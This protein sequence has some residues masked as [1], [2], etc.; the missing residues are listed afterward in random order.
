MPSVVVSPERERDAEK[1]ASKDL[2]NLSLSLSSAPSSSPFPSPSSSFIPPPMPGA[3]EFA[4]R[5]SIPSSKKKQRSDDAA[6]SPASVAAVAAVVASANGGGGGAAAAPPQLHSS[7]TP[8]AQSPPNTPTAKRTSLVVC[9]LDNGVEP[10]TP[11]QQQHANHTS[12]SSTR[13]APPSPS[14]SRR[15]SGAQTGAASRPVSRALSTATRRSSMAASAAAQRRRSRAVKIRDFAFPAGDPRHTGQGPDAPRASAEY[16][17]PGGA[18][19]GG[20]GTDSRRSSGWGA[21]RWAGSKLWGLALGGGSGGRSGGRTPTDGDEFVPTRSDFERNFDVTSPAEEYPGGAGAGA[22]YMDDYDEDADDDEGVYVD[23]H[24]DGEEEEEGYPDPEVPLLPG[25]YRAL[26]AFEP[27]GT[28][29]MAL[30]EDQVVH[31]VG[32]GGGVGWAIAEDEAGGHALVPESYLELVKLD[33]A[34]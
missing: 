29:E 30:T 5:L 20:G 15:A 8:P 17:S 24:G 32:R 12:L 21:F 7:T 23:S 1:R 18:G 26:Y 2:P 31:I 9:S 27:E 33:E 25:M 13:R 6:E 11:Q 34:D 16:D 19:G 22:G 14:V 10:S 4:N 3:H 28:A